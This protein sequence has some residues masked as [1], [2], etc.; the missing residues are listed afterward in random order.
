M[1][2]RSLCQVQ[3]KGKRFRSIC[4]SAM[5]SPFKGFSNRFSL[6][7]IRQKPF[8]VCCYYFVR[9]GSRRCG[10]ND[11]KHEQFDEIHVAVCA[12]QIAD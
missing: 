3:L 2:V 10:S 5:V 6:P 1:K 7:S 11:N 12:W 8:I 4:V 9:I